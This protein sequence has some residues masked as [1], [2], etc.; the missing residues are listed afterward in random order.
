M[1]AVLLFRL[2]GTTCGA[3]PDSHAILSLLYT[4][5]CGD[6]DLRVSSLLPFVGGKLYLP[7]PTSALGS[8][9]RHNGTDNNRRG[10]ENS[11]VEIPKFLRS[12]IKKGTAYAP[13]DV[14]CRVHDENF[15]EE[16]GSFEAVLIKDFTVPRNAL[17]RVSSKSNLYFESGWYAEHTHVQ[18]G[19]PPGGDCPGRRVNTF[20]VLLD[21]DADLERIETSLVGM[22]LGGNKTHGAVIVGVE[23]L[24]DLQGVRVNRDGGLLVSIA[25]P[26]DRPPGHIPVLKEK[27]VFYN[28][29]SGVKRRAYPVY[30]PGSVLLEGEYEAGD[31]NVGKDVRGYV[32]KLFVRPLFVP[33]STGE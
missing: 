25:R 5:G 31:V 27:W 1:V 30:C 15:W 14:V 29:G 4:A 13:L 28:D 7:V 33:V 18:L 26:S 6:P 9:S 21:G 24:D 32:V 10:G 12:H 16:K 19:E 22:P 20:A 8:F 11:G 17:D 23:T 2:H 3:Y